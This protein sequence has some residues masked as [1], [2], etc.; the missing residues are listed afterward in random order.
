MQIY[1]P[2]TLYAVRD[3]DSAKG[4]FDFEDDGE[5]QGV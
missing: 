2:L 1:T 3:Q 5:G 4:Y